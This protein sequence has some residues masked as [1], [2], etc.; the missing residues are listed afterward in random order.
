METRA[1]AGLPESALMQ[2]AGHALAAL[3]MAIAP[4]ARKIWVACGPGNNG[5]DGL[6][7]ARQL[8]LMGKE[9]VVTCLSPGTG[10]ARIVPSA[11]ARARA[12]GVAFSEQAPDRFDASI[13]ALFGI[14][15]RGECS[16]RASDWVA[17]MNR[18][19]GP[20]L[21]ADI[22]TGLDADTGVAGQVCVRATHT[23][24][25]L[26]LKPGLF[27]ADGRMACG[28][29]WWN[30][31]GVP[32][33]AGAS[34][35]LA[36]VPRRETR[37]HNTHKGSYGDVAVIGGAK[38][39]AG[40]ALLA[41]RA[42]L[43]GGAGRVYVA[44]LDPALP[45]LDR[46][47]PE[48]MFRQPAALELARMAVVAGCGGGAAIDGHLATL[49]RESLYLVLDAD[50]LNQLALRP[51]L[52]SAVA[53]RR[54]GSTV[55]T[56]H[57]G[58]A[59]RLLG[60]ATADIQA[61]RLR[62]AQALCDK[63]ACTVVLKGSGTIIAAPQ[64]LPTINATGNARLATAGTGDV[65]AGLIGALLAYHHDASVACREACFRHGLAADTW[66]SP[67]ALTAASL[68]AAL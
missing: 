60:V 51:D 35:W 14:G 40:A 41:G 47:Q 9:P 3:A 6:E 39:M 16:G 30:R 25:L 67:H 59:G 22:P 2:R 19:G 1:L 7:A 61:D 54:P 50:A 17:Q 56:P 28:D 21:A 45:A 32:G 57:P 64:V 66:R 23:L 37:A 13:D 55:L 63:F 46:M 11:L 42:A 43:H 18:S 49:V 5:G 48:L 24:T 20:V 52:H 34:A 29:I 31:L 44:M 68:I 8:R 4:H 53:R 62:H 33:D 38:G 65:L 10:G 12:A 27:T 58:E 26:T 36:G 15:M